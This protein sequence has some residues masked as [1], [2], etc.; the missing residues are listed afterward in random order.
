LPIQSIIKRLADA[1]EADV[2]EFWSGDVTL[3]DSTAVDSTRI[4]AQ[5]QPTDIYLLCL[6]VVHDGRFVTFDTSIPLA[7]VRKAAARRLV[8]L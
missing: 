3:L 5:R 7:A 1:Y 8:V 4:H 2:H 6:A